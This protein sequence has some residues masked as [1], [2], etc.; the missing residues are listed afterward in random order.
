MST[1]RPYLILHH[2]GDIQD[3][4]QE[5][6]D[7]LQAKVVELD[8]YESGMELTH[9]ITTGEQDYNSL[10]RMFN[11]VEDDIK[12]VALGVVKDYP[13]FIANNGRFIVD[14][15]WFSDQM[16]K[17]ALDKFFKGQASV[18]LDE[19][20]PSMKEGSSFKVTNHLRIGNDMDRLSAFVHS[21]DGSV[22]NVRT[23]VDHAL[24]YLF[25]LKQ[26]GIGGAP[27][28]VDY[29]HTGHETIVQIHLPVKNYVAEY[30]LDSFGEPNGQDPLRYLLAI[31]AQSTDYMEVQY[32]Q[33]A[34]KLVLTGLWQN[35][36][37]VRT[38]RFGS[39]L[40]NQVFTTAQIERNIEQQLMLA[41]TKTAEE[42]EELNNKSLPGHLLEMVMPETGHDGYLKDHPDLAKNLVAFA[43][44][45]WKETNP[46]Q[47]I[48]QVTET[49]MMDMLTDYFDA[50]EI[51]NLQEVDVQHVMDRVRKNN[52]SQA[53]EQEIDRV[54]GS[55]KDDEKFQQS[56]KDTFADKVAEKISGDFD[57]ANMAELIKGTQAELDVPVVVSGGAGEGDAAIM[58]KGK[59]AKDDMIQKISGSIDSEI[60]SQMIKGSKI[61]TDDFVMRI[62]QGIGDQV[63]GDWK[64]KSNLVD[65]LAPKK[66]QDHLTRFATK[67]GQT[68]DKLT[69]SDLQ[70]FAQ[71]ELPKIMDEFVT[72]D[73]SFVIPE[74]VLPELPDYKFQSIFK[75]ELQA[76]MQ[77]LYPG[78]SA[79]EA[80][81]LIT[82]EEQEK[83]LREVL[84][85]SVKKIVASNPGTDEAA[86]I[87]TLSHYLKGSE[88]DI[89]TII[90][91]SRE[92]VKKIESAQVI[93][94]LFSPP[95]Q[96]GN[97]GGNS[98]DAANGILIQ[99][100]RQLE[101][102]FNTAK[103]QLEAANTE[104]KVLKDARNQMHK[105][106]VKSKDAV[107]AMMAQES[108]A[109][110]ALLP[111]NQ[112]MQ[113]IQDLASGKEINPE[114]AQR[115]KEAL[116]REQQILQAAK[117]AELDI[118]KAK[119]EMQQKE[120][121]FAQEIEKA[122]RALKSRDIVVQKAK[123]GLALM[124]AKK[125]K[126]ISDLNIKVSTMVG[127][128]NNS[129]QANNAQKLRALEQEKQSMSRLVEVYK[130][131][132]TSMA[133][134]ME[135]QGSSSSPKKDEEVR[136]ITMD[137]QRAEVALQAAQKDL[138]KLK[139]RMEL[140]QAET[141]RLRAEKSRLEEAL[142]SAISTS[143]PI[144]AQASAKT[145]D[146]SGKLKKLEL[147]LAMESQRAGKYEISIKELEAKVAEL[148][149]ALAK[150]G[151]NP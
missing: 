43:I 136:K 108:E 9:I 96:S 120:S 131:K 46:D 45:K 79:D 99:R 93:E 98:G 52:V 97:E 101:S 69:S 54:R 116:E 140:D 56:L 44:D 145:E 37:G 16:G 47:D 59:K 18:H 109:D 81:G 114:D 125:D 115:L 70:L 34:S 60:E 113:M 61:K 122:N 21:H 8:G 89:K 127:A 82:P 7:S 95:T 25:Y 4:L 73:E 5:Y 57:E 124:M 38:L 29:G 134:N 107:N 126:E 85:T 3:E 32:I 49:Q 12:I 75:N 121:F 13:S 19:N 144:G 132:L 84:K 146:Q 31:C 130:N 65:T 64:Y 63:K 106:D 149:G 129:P 141:Q 78:K 80:S 51:A 118:K 77:Q 53:Y 27:F 102:E 150:A 28:E 36:K 105:I 151:S 24:Y 10:G 48:A 128:M 67:M 117:Q 2:A 62:S 111:M 83:L 1:N 23:Y 15:K 14:Q 88:A 71:S 92:E 39:L 20:F 6:L 66:V 33:S 91:G 142:K 133:S 42:L 100:L 72:V 135:K 35:K 148:T 40:I 76:K 58:V 55:L 11:T 41:K 143:G 112:K 138:T 30:L 137:K 123:D 17:V 74:T 119:L 68:L 22:V 104:L 103:G 86:L 139:S 90:S 94:K 87:K 147:D 26:A 110:A 50:G